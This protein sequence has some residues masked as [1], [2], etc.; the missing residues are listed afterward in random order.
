MPVKLV[1]NSYGK[2]SVRLTKVTRHPDCHDLAELTVNIRLE[3]DFA[4]SYTHGDNR[5]V[6][7]T[8]SMKNTVYVLA[9]RHPLNSPESFA[10][11]L[12]GHFVQTYEQVSRAEVEIEQ[13]SWRRIDV[14]GK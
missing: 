7:A 6:A 3:G 5:N 12:A 4:R 10:L 2:S 13:S 14:A 9:K 8:D 1:Q 11:H